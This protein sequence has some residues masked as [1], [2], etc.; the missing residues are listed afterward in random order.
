V[1]FDLAGLC[2]VDEPQFDGTA[3]SPVS[4]GRGHLAWMGPEEW[5]DDIGAGT[6]LAVRV[7]RDGDVTLTSLPAE[8]AVDPVLVDA[9]GDPASAPRPGRVSRTTPQCRSM[10]AGRRLHPARTTTPAGIPIGH[11]PA[12]PSVSWS[13]ARPGPRD[14]SGRPV[15]LPAPYA[16]SRA[17]SCHVLRRVGRVIPCVA[18]SVR[19]WAEMD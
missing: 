9:Q 8:P 17:R 12:Q 6:V 13:V 18:I 5:L 16:W 1:S 10:T 4:P 2:H 7:S 14:L 19:W 11:R 3:L 15:T